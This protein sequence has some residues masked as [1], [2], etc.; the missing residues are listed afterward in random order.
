MLESTRNHYKV[1]SEVKLLSKAFSLIEKSI[2]L[3]I[4]LDYILEQGKARVEIKATSVLSPEYR[5][6]NLDSIPTSQSY[7][8]IVH[9][10]VRHPPS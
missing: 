5:K 8:I 3:Y 1:K 2:K 9:S 6:P 7:S 10:L 4:Y